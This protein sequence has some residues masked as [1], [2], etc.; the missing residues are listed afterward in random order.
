MLALVVLGRCCFQV[1]R[2]ASLSS[3]SDK[4]DKRDCRDI[5]LPASLGV[6]CHPSLVDAMTTANKRMMS[7]FFFSLFLVLASGTGEEE[8]CASTGCSGMSLLQVQQ[9]TQQ[10]ASALLHTQAHALLRESSSSRTARA[11]MLAKTHASLNLWLNEIAWGVALRSKNH[12]FTRSR[13]APA[14]K[15]PTSCRQLQVSSRSA[16]G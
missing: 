3:Y 2:P 1:T 16:P 10:R 7:V 15:R 14:G 9:T 5:A 4:H 13:S 11:V 6:Y 12:L 8:V